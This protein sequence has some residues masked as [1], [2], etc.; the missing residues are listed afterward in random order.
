[1]D[2]RVMAIGAF[3]RLA[4]PSRSAIAESLL[5]SM[6]DG[7]LWDEPIDGEIFIHRFRDVA[8]A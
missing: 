8:R 7:E 3:G 4:S 2:H 6:T 5:R 1:M